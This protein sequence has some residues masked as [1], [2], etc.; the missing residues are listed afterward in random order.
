MR[1][2]L[3]VRG[4][5]DAFGPKGTRMRDFLRRQLAASVAK[6]TRAVAS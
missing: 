3:Q 2:P 6:V 1:E 5:F 4:D